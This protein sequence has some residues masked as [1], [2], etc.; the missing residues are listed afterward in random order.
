M[1]AE[2][3]HSAGHPSAETP[4]NITVNIYLDEEQLD[5]TVVST[6]RDLRTAQTNPYTLYFPTLHFF[7][8]FF[9]TNRPGEHFT[10]FVWTEGRFVKKN[11]V[12]NLKFGFVRERVFFSPLNSRSQSHCR[13]IQNLTYNKS[14]KIAFEITTF[15]CYNLGC[16]S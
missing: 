12:S 1:T 5:K 6:D 2:R 9:F 13:N 14:V 16:H 10:G 15:E 3:V 7:F 8:F 4:P 11:A